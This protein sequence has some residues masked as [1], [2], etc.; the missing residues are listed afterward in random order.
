MLISLIEKWQEN[1]SLKQI[2]PT[3]DKYG[4][5]KPEMGIFKPTNQNYLKTLDEGC[6]IQL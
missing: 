5:L 6:G 3:F 2:L 4:N 1:V